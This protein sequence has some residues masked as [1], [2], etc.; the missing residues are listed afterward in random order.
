MSDQPSD[1][2][3]VSLFDDETGAPIGAISPAQLQFLVNQ[4]EEEDAEDDNYYVDEA[5]LDLL[6]ERGADASLLD[7]LRAALAG[8]GHVE[9]RFTRPS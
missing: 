9:V 8:R 4:L 7:T 1:A 5:T 2:A 3:T 6:A